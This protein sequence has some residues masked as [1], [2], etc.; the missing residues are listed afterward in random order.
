[1]NFGARMQETTEQKDLLRQLYA[2]KPAFRPVFDA[3]ATYVYGRKSVKIDRIHRIVKGK[4]VN[5]VAAFKAVEEIGLGDYVKGSWGHASRFDF[6]GTTPRRVGLLAQGVDDEEELDDVDT[7]IE[8][9]LDEDDAADGE[10]SGAGISALSIEEL[11]AE[12]KRRGARE[13]TVL[14]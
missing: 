11:I 12:I 3:L 1:M 6:A 5:V 7:E 13:V 4:R 8:A 10:L 14:F 2:D 9:E